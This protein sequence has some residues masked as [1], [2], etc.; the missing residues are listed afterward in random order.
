MSISDLPQLTTSY[1]EEP[2]KPYEPLSDDEELGPE[3]TASG[4]VFN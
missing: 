4:N 2:G 1:E 3:G